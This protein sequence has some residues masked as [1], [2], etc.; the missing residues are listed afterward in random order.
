MKKVFEYLKWVLN[1]W[2][3]SQKMWILGA[4]FFGWGI[5]DYIKT[6]EINT[7]ISIAF[8]IWGITFIKWFVW[9]PILDSWARFDK[10]RK[11]LFKTID[12]GK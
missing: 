7:A 9:D 10:E 12:E 11:D 5:M 3:F 2:T 8:T 1:R 6:Q 4:Y